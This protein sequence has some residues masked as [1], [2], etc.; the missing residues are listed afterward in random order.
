M[1]IAVLQMSSFFQSWVKIVTN[2]LNFPSLIKG[3]PSGPS[4]KEPAC[5]CRRH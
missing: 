1:I 4:V 5:Q 3:I 2:F